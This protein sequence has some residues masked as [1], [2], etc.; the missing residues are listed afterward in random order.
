M[1]ICPRLMR[2]PS[3]LPLVVLA[4]ALLPWTS[5]GAQIAAVPLATANGDFV[6]SR[7]PGNRNA[8]PQRQWLVVDRDPAGLNC[9]DDRGQVVALL[10]YGAVVDSDLKGDGTEAIVVMA[11]RPWLRLLAHPF[12]LRQDLR[13]QGQRLLP[14]ACRVQA[15]AAFIAPLNPDTVQPLGEQGGR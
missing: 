8:Y 11:G 15:N 2:R 10:A 14:V 1:V 9:R 5:A 3:Y 13:P 12:D 4:T 7:L 6:S